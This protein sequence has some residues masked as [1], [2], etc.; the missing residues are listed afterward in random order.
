MFTYWNKAISQ[1]SM[2][3][4]RGHMSRIT[5]TFRAT[6]TRTENTKFTERLLETVTVSDRYVNILMVNWF[7]LTSTS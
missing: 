5:H 1:E 2:A 7:Q 6:N 4:Y 3:F